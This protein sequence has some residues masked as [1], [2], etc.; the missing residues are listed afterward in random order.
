MY[1]ETGSEGT[2]Y[3][4]GKLKIEL[5]VFSIIVLCISYFLFFTNGGNTKQTRKKETFKL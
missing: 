1:I 4:L 5:L 2:T 3:F